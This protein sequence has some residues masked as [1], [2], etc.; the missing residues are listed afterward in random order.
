MAKKIKK[1][2]FA[3]K[4]GECTAL[5]KTECNG[6]HFYKHSDNPAEDQ[7]R[8]ERECACYMGKCKERA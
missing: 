7:E 6:C 1:D 4:D 8:I 2:C 5:N 3:I